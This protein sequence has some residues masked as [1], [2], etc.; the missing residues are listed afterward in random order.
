MLP[1]SSQASWKVLILSAVLCASAKLL[2]L[3]GPAHGA[4][5]QEGCDTT[6]RSGMSLLQVNQ[7]LWDSNA[8][9]VPSPP[10]APPAVSALNSASS[11]SSSESEVANVSSVVV[12]EDLSSPELLPSYSN[13]TEEPVPVI[14]SIEGAV[15]IPSLGPG[16]LTG[17][18]LDCVL[19]DWSDWSNCTRSDMTAT[20]GAFQFREREILQ[21]HLQGGKICDGLSEIA[22]CELVTPI[23]P[24]LNNR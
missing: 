20:M 16:D 8:S 21:P 24:I 14:S 3:T 15:A 5:Y 13:I 10:P 23:T 11:N 7:K 19:S 2:D 22:E 17:T 9:E 1:Q 4:V 18:N 12:W 6:L